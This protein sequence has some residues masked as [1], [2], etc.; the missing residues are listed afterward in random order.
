[1]AEFATP[2]AA[3]M[4]T[5]GTDI[6]KKKPE[7]PDEELYNKNLKQAEKEHVE[8]MAKLVYISLSHSSFLLSLTSFTY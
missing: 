2:S 6:E 1:M 8:A 3:T 7:K 4:A 5:V